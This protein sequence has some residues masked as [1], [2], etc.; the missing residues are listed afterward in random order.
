MASLASHSKGGRAAKVMQ[1][2]D[3]DRA[4]AP[5]REHDA[6]QTSDDD[7][8][9]GTQAGDPQRGPVHDWCSQ[10]DAEAGDRW[11]P[12]QPSAVVD[13]GE[14]TENDGNGDSRWKQPR[15]SPADGAQRDRR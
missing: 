2:H 13:G 3:S 15:Q 7:D 12:H 1:H 6:D 14:H 4:A 9:C 5:R 10:L 11:I 8:R